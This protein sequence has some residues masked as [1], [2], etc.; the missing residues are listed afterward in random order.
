[1]KTNRTRDNDFVA[2]KHKKENESNAKLIASAPN[3]LEELQ[4]ISGRIGTV[5]PN[6]A[7]CQALKD[8]ADKAIKKA[9]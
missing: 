9:I 7:F 5:R 6:D 3:L 2:R 8:I 1:M 4:H